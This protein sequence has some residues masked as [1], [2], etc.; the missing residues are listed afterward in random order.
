MVRRIENP[1]VWRIFKVRKRSQYRV[2]RRSTLKAHQT[3]DIL[4]Q[5][6]IGFEFLHE[7]QVVEK[8]MVSSIVDAS[9][10]GVDAET[11]AGRATCEQ[12]KIPL[13][14]AQ[15]PSDV[16]SVHIS[17]VTRIDPGL[18]M[19]CFVCLRV[20]AHD[21]VCVHT[22]EPGG[23]KPQGESARPSEE[24]NHGALS[25]HCRLQYRLCTSFVGV[26][27]AIS[28]ALARNSFCTLWYST[29]PKRH[30]LEGSSHLCAKSVS[31]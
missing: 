26:Q 15:L 6:S 8:E 1:N 17:N 19:V 22:S 21:F 13:L 27:L 31:R 10:R 23:L 25:S 7:L 18:W 30:S 29:P 5:N 2:Q 20:L 11:L 4:D 12:S 16:P 9:D 24:I 28:N 3:W 14:K